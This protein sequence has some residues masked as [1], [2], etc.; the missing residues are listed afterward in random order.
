MGKQG[1]ICDD[2]QLGL[3]FANGGALAER[4]ELG[5]ETGGTKGR[6]F[7][8]RVEKKDDEDEEAAIEI[9][10]RERGGEVEGDRL[11]ETHQKADSSIYKGSPGV[12]EVM[13]V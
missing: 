7:A 9:A 6:A 1:F 12:G 10:E 4:V 5:F 13:K 11:Q 8:E 3:G 2:D